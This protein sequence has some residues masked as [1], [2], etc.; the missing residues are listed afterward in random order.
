MRDGRSGIGC[1]CDANRKK[2]GLLSP[3]ATR[4]CNLYRLVAEIGTVGQ[5]AASDV[6][7]AFAGDP[8]NP[9][10]TFILW[11]DIL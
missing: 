7:R 9:V 8:L 5:T 1:D 4:M 2:I 11:A 3:A 6:W 10:I